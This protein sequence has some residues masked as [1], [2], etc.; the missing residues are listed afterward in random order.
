MRA[1]FDCGNAAPKPVVYA[2]HRIR[3]VPIVIDP[4]MAVLFRRSERHSRACDASGLE[5][6]AGT[7]AEQAALRKK[8]RPL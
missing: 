6:G 5:H 3:T 8:E 4:R 1:S 2:E 7:D